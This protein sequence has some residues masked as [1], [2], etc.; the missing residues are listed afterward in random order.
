MRD[1]GKGHFVTIPTVLIGKEDGYKILEYAS[2]HPII[3][4]AFELTEKEKSD[5]TLWVDVLDHKNYIFLREFQS[6]FNRIEQD[7]NLCAI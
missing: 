5:V 4:V 6:Y 7:S 2:Q 3:S 1:D